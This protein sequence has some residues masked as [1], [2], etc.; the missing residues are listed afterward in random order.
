MRP[1]AASII[2]VAASAS[3]AEFDPPPTPVI[4][5]SDVGTKPPPDRAP[6][7]MTRGEIG[8]YNKGLA[9]NHPYYITCRK[10]PVMGSLA[11]KLRVCRTNEQWKTFAARGN[12]EGHAI[13]D[14]MSHA[15]VNSG[16]SVPY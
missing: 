14:E 10:D 4:V 16:S 8:A 11:R 2:L 9:R 3:A 15:P 5:S 13:M 7:L 6:S 12:D 1:I